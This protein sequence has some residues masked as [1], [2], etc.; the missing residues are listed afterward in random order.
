METTMKQI[1]RLFLLLCLIM[2]GAQSA[3]AQTSY[4]ISICGVAITSDNYQNISAEGGFPAVISGSVTFD[5]D[6]YT[7]TL[8]G[9]TISTSVSETVGIYCNRM[10]Q[11]YNPV[12]WNLVIEG[13]N[14]VSVTGNALQS[15]PGLT[16]SG[17]GS[18]ELNSTNYNGIYIDGRWQT[19]NIQDCSVSAQGSMYGICGNSSSELYLSISGALVRANGS[20]GSIAR[21][22]NLT[23]SSDCSITLPEGA[24][25]NTSKYAVCDTSGNPISN[26][27]V[28]IRGA[29]P[30]PYAVFENKKLTF[31]YDRL[32]SSHTSGTTYDIPWNSGGGSDV[33][34]WSG[35]SSIETIDFDE[36]FANYH[37]LTSAYSMFFN[38]MK[39]SNINNLDRLNTENVTNMMAMFCKTGYEVI[40][41]QSFDLSKF[42]TSNVTNMVSM[43]AYCSVSSL[44]LSSFNTEKVTNMSSMFSYCGRLTS[45]NLSS[46]NT[47]EVTSMNTMFNRCTQLV[48]ID[49]SSF[50]T[51]KVTNM[52]NMFSHC[53]GLKRLNLSNFNTENVTNMSHM[54]GYCTSLLKVNLS[55]FN[56]AK[57]T[58][59]L[60]MFNYCSSLA[61]LDLSTFE[62]SNVTDM[63]GM[64]NQCS[65]LVSLDLTS[66]NTSKVTNMK[67]MFGYCTDLTTIY[68]NDTWKATTSEL[69][70]DHCIS[71]S[72]P[73]LSYDE[74]KITVEYANPTTGYF[75]KVEP[76][77]ADVLTQN[78]QLVGEQ[79]GTFQI[80]YFD[81]YGTE[82]GN[83]QANNEHPY[84]TFTSSDEKENIKRLQINVAVPQG[85]TFRA[86][87]N[88]Q[89][90]TGFT[91]DGSNYT[92][93]LG[94][95]FVIDG[96][97]TYVVKKADEVVAVLTPDKGAPLFLINSSGDEV[98]LATNNTEIGTI[99]KGGDYTIKVHN[100]NKNSWKTNLRVNGTDRTDELVTSSDDAYDQLLS[101]TNIT[102]SLNV[103]VFFTPLHSCVFLYTTEGGTTMM[104]YTHNTTGETTSQTYIKGDHMNDLIAYDTD[105][106]FTFTPEQGYKLSKVFVKGD[107]WIGEGDDYEVKL[108]ADGSYRF[109]LHSWDFINGEASVTVH[110]EKKGGPYDVN[111]DGNV[112]IADVTKLVNVILGKE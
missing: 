110:Y 1:R 53:S 49:V 86:Y 31:Y 2:V 89:E 111:N 10:D 13:A 73:A 37:G 62:T 52:G 79:L 56:T 11:S 39:V 82:Y 40:N 96:T 29:T 7:L 48:S 92:V 27:W 12:A 67:N 104:E 8:N 38:L 28:E 14:S 57:V 54:F 47:A 24:T 32:R 98:L 83:A 9:A 106:V 18:I 44:D 17:S 72:S 84:V 15:T 101:L 51:A 68:C 99:T 36:S 19:L 102:E 5:P 30:E 25:F 65:N 76:A 58:N 4:N 21:I 81:S 103:E 94:E 66:F 105:V 75:T 6:T 42:N 70:F 60:S 107:R 74:N 41:L 109:V 64:F 80:R 22:K 95:A 3:W 23:M 87:F 59:M 33:P 69:M 97:W 35:N 112:T 50:N 91:L 61:V 77:H 26:Q 90:V 46:F 85:Y 43:F 93:T 20:N 100:S 108:Q 78:I 55:S 63:A 45:L 34:G 88:G 71:L 16:I